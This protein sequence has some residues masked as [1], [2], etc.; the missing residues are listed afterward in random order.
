MSTLREQIETEPSYAVLEGDD[1][2]TAIEV[3]EAGSKSEP[4]KLRLL[5]LR[6]LEN[7]P[8]KWEPGGSLESLPLQ[9]GQY[10]VDATHVS[11]W[12][13]GIV[14]QDFHANAPRLGRLSYF[15]RTKQKEYVSFELLYQPDMIER[16]NELRGHL[17]SIEIG[18]NKPHH[19]SADSGAFG[20]LIPTVFRSRA[21]SVNI[22]M[23]MGRT[24]RRNSFLDTE[25]EDAAYE[26]AEQAQDYVDRMVIGGYNTRT[27]KIESINL[28]HE[29]I[30]EHVRLRPNHQVPTLPDLSD[31]FAKLDETY[32]KF[33]T[34]GVFDHALTTK[35]VRKG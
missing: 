24:S 3:I 1:I 18:I 19:V 25:T 22:K 6:T 30:Q 28:M 12:P 14:G 23:G 7:R 11:I 32:R 5:A 15:I 4:V 34:S 9:D 17:R 13:D 29:R 21:P 33:Q 31:V 27:E 10:P 35:A 20:T 16:L 26:I 2:S 8:H